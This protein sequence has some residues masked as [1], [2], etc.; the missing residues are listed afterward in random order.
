MRYLMK[1]I[2]FFYCCSSDLNQNSLDGAQASTSEVGSAVE[3]TEEDNAVA[4][5]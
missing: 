3:I 1:F 5:I 4:T 2:R